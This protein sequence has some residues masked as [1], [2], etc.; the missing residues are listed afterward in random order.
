MKLLFLSVFN[1]IK[2]LLKR[3]T[4]CCKRIISIC[5]D[6][7]ELISELGCPLFACGTNFH[8]TKSPL[9]TIALKESSDW[10]ATPTE[11]EIVPNRGENTFF[12][13]LIDKVQNE[14]IDG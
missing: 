8:Q 4:S 7:T 13:L 5:Y 1:R 10:D 3:T 12:S 6:L 11:F 14:H 2:M 9:G